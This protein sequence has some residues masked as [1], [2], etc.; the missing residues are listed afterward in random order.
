MSSLTGFWAGTYWYPDPRYPAVKFD[1]ELRLDGTTL[2]GETTEVDIFKPSGTF[3]LK[4]SLSGH[5]D[6]RHIHFA[7]TYLNAGPHYSGVVQYIGKLNFRK[8]RM[9]GHWSVEDWSGKFVMARDKGEWRVSD[10]IEAANDQ[11]IKV[12][13]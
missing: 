13:G 7:K 10:N 2:K 4:A 11:D 5:L 9:S 1:C 12:F 8:T 6:G 3:I